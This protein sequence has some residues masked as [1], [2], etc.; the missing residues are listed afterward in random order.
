MVT[1]L[2]AGLLYRI[3]IRLKCFKDV[4]VQE[5]E[6]L[7]ISTVKIRH[8]PRVRNFIPHVEVHGLKWNEI[9]SPRANPINRSISI[10]TVGG[11]TTASI[12]AST[13]LSD[14]STTL[15][16]FG[17]VGVFVLM[18]LAHKIKRELVSVNERREQEALAA[19]EEIENLSWHDRAT[20]LYSYSWF[21]QAL[22]RE[23]S[24]SKRYDQPCSLLWMSLDKRALEAQTIHATNADPNHV[25][26]F[27][28]DLVS[29]SVRNTD[30][31]ARHPEEYSV[32]ILLPQT[33]S[34]GIHVVSNRL[35]ERLKIEKLEIVDGSFL[36]VRFNRRGV[37][38]PVDGSSADELLEAVQNR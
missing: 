37:S 12:V 23:V 8:H 2:C 36:E 16:T 19:K 18:L 9:D 14:F 30:T 25:W 20:G 38:F 31:V 28:S 10:V 1:T 27:V 34:D 35:S 7:R 33:D 13:M 4:Y 29:A 15:S 32:A 6:P 5:H 26:R 11:V 21:K 24:R 17:V 22:E 3:Q